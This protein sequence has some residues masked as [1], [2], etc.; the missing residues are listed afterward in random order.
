MIGIGLVTF[1][2][3]L[4]LAGF[5]QDFFHRS[6]A[7]A[8]SFSNSLVGHRAFVELLKR[9]GIAVVVSKS[10]E[11]SGANENFALLLLEPVDILRD[12]HDSESGEILADKNR[13]ELYSR[14][15][16]PALMSDAKVVL[17]LPKRWA[18]V[19][20]LASGWIG[21]ERIMRIETVQR[22]LSDVL[23]AT[24]CVPE[25]M[26]AD[27]VKRV[28]TPGKFSSSHMG[29]M[30]QDSIHV[31]VDAPLQVLGDIPNATP[32]VFSDQGSLIASLE[33]GVVLISD[34]DLFNNRSLAR[35]D[36]AA[37]MLA[38][39]ADYLHAQGVVV[40]ETMHG[41]ESQRG[42]IGYALAF[43][44]V[45]VSIHFF[46]SMFMA[47]WVMGGYFGKPLAPPSSLHP[48]KD[49]L[50]DNTARLLLDAGDQAG[51]LSRYSSM[52][53][54]KVARNFGVS[55]RLDTLQE[56]TNSR[57]MHMDLAMIM[58]KCKAAGLTQAD[59]VHLAGQIHLWA[60]IVQGYDADGVC[61]RE[62]QRGNGNGAISTTGT[63]GKDA[64]SKGGDGFG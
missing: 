16:M 15:I 37:I 33:C 45:L 53:M 29:I 51:V 5:G 13:Q 60:M 18:S 61:G 25:S 31:Q 2:L 63:D 20:E 36:N 28:K 50:I 42:I 11:S 49:L 32:L 39:L 44:L 40:D 14:R 59:V 35:A 3:G 43:P 56:L 24:G 26:S 55:A 64:K 4:L 6:S 34:P 22:I 17:A 23:S 41:F 54:A 30:G 52:V 48:G 1:I 7:G 10:K 57:G 47:F 12:I 46:L 19:S 21:T 62:T 9:S 38:L 58:R 27:L 8:S